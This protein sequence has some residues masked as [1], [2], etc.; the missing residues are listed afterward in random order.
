MKSS[1]VA[2]NERDALYRLQ[3][4]QFARAPV[5]RIIWLL[6]ASEH[7]SKSASVMQFFRQNETKLRVRHEMCDAIDGY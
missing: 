3:N 5:V 7:I 1:A 4:L 6:T 2:K